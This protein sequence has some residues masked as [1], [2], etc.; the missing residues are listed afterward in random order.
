MPVQYLSFYCIYFFVLAHLKKPL[1][2]YVDKL[3]KVKILRSQKREGLIR[4]R[5]YGAA[6]STGEVL[7]FLDS[8]CE[9]TEG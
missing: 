2:D 4:A 8:H 9:C 5:L 7:I 3:E 6:K 1:Q